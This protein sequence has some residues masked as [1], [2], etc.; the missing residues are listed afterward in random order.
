MGEPARNDGPVLNAFGRVLG[1]L[2]VLGYDAEWVGVR[3]AD[4]GAPHGRYRVF[5]VAN[6]SR[7]RGDESD[8]SAG[9][10]TESVDRASV[11]DERSPRP[12][13]TE[14]CADR[15]ATS[16]NA[17]GE[18]FGQYARESSSQEARSGSSDLTNGSSGSRTDTNWGPY[19]PA[20]ERWEQVLGRT[21]PSPTNPD[22]KNGSHRL[23][24]QFVE[25]MQG[26]PAGHVTDPVIGL[27]RNQQLKALGNGVVPAQCALALRVLGVSS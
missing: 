24:A 8:H 5:I 6:P 14:W 19:R 10:S 7:I 13:A 20:I 16:T 23:S 17:G 26:L 2:A 4:A 11:A 22:G 12:G 21:A 18:R 15:P 27:T 1:D 3:A 25:W 9:F